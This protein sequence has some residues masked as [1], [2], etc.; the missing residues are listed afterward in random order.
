VAGT[1]IRGG[2]F[3]G[4]E[5]SL[6]DLDDSDLKFNVDFRSVYATVLEQV[7][8]VDAPSVLG[9]RFPTLDFV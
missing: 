5:P 4:E 7:M 1:G 3:Y 2:R 9:S 8:G 6:T